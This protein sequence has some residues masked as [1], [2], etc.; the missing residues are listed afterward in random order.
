MYNVCSCGCFHFYR[1][2]EDTKALEES[3]VAVDND[4]AAIGADQPSK[5]V[6]DESRDNINTGEGGA[7]DSSVKS[8]AG[9]SVKGGAGDGVGSGTS[10]GVE[11]GGVEGGTGDSVK[12]EARDDVDGEPIKAQQTVQESVSNTVSNSETE[13][14]GASENGV[15]V[16]KGGDDSPSVNAASKRSGRRRNKFKV[17]T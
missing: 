1:P 8:G 10:D 2:L 4:A 17:Q 9:D 15:D 13:N 11:G 5:I 12:S 7:G 16:K 3:V 14:V 6:E